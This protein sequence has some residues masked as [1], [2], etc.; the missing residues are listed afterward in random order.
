M[1]YLISVNTLTLTVFKV[2]SDNVYFE[3]I[4]GIAF[5]RHAER[6]DHAIFR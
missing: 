6:Q 3:L 2:L 5:K 4:S 1:A